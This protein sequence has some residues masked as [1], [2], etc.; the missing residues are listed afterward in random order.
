MAELKIKWRAFLW[1]AG[2]LKKSSHK[3]LQK[4]TTSPLKIIKA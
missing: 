2:H 3:P 4:Q 1:K